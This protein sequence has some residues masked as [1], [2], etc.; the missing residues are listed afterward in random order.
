[1][2][3]SN[4]FVDFVKSTHGPP[5]IDDE[6]R[7]VNQ[8]ATPVVVAQMLP[9]PL[10]L[11]RYAFV[12]SDSEGWHDEGLTQQAKFQMMKDAR[13]RLCKRIALASVARFNRGMD[14]FWER[15]DEFRV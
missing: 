5:Y 13:R 9:T 3:Y 12:L 1:M 2:K 8:P 11:Q 15:I 14:F 6:L 4:M 10:P 7:H